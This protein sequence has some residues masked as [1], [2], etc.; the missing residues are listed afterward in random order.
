MLRAK[1]LLAM[2]LLAVPAPAGAISV[3]A[4]FFDGPYGYG[5]SAASV[6]ARAKARVIGPEDEWLLAGGPGSFEGSGLVVAN[7]LSAVHSNP[8]AGRRTPSAIDPLVADSVWTVTNRTDQAI[9][10]GFLLFTLI[11]QDRRYPG[12]VAGLDGALLEILEYS[13]AGTDYFFGGAR[14]PALGVG[15]S[16]D[17]TVRYIVAGAVDY[18]PE[19]NSYRLPRLGLAG[20]VVPEPITLSALALGLAALAGERARRR[21]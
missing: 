5:F 14:L 12:L 1:R 18:D 3:D 4:L 15:E 7:Q 20:L 8:Q 16:F 19:T 17:L 11:D 13:S 6:A 9:P 2:V 21:L 10:E